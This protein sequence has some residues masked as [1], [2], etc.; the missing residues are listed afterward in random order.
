MPL[1]LNEKQSMDRVDRKRRKEISK[2]SKKGQS[3]RVSF[4]HIH[5]MVI[6]VSCNLNLNVQR[7]PLMVKVS[8]LTHTDTQIQVQLYLYTNTTSFQMPSSSMVTE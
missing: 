2:N 5:L 3:E 6:H 7:L 8:L 4:I 1:E